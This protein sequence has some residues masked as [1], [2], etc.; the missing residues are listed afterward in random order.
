MV[1]GVLREYGEVRS[2]NAGANA[3]SLSVEMIET[4]TGRVVWAA[5]T[6]Q[7]GVG[8]WDRLLGGGGEPMNKV[9]E[10]AVRALLKQLFR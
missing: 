8:F 3:I 10:D 4:A 2:G 1:T 7:G 5:S 6:T 9:T